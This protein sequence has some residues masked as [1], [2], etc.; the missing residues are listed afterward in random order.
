MTGKILVLVI[1]AASIG[2]GGAI[3]YLQVYA[4]YRVIPTAEVPP[5]ALVLRADGLSD[6]IDV[7]NAQ[8]IDSDSSPLRFRSCFSAV[9]APQQLPDTYVQY[10]NPTPL[11]APAWFD[12]FDAREIG[13]ALEAGQ[14]QAYLSEANFIYGFDRVVAILP[15]GRGFV[16][17]QLNNCG[18]EVFDGAAAPEG[19][20]PA[21]ERN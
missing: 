8:A 13:A 4:Y 1:L 17:P 21:P 5:V 18:E 20:P 12:C 3:Y 9:D 15:D 14:A 11:I 6:V 2:I 10:G 19:C 7:R 16:W